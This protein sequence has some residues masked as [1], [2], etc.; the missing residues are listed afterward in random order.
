MQRVGFHEYDNQFVEVADIFISWILIRVMNYVQFAMQSTLRDYY[1]SKLELQSKPS[2]KFT[3]VH[4]TSNIKIA[5]LA[6][7]RAQLSKFQT[8]RRVADR[9]WYRAR[10]LCYSYV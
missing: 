4:W 2:A 10:N 1:N 7:S 9:I 3:F 8:R 5:E 6:G